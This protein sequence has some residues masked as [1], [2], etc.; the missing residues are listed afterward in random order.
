MPWMSAGPGAHRPPGAG[1]ILIMAALPMEVRP[2]L[3]QAKARP[4]RDLGVP[5]WEWESGSGVVALSGMGEAAARRAGET[6]IG[7]CRPWLLVSWGFAGALA[8][9]L[10]V[11]DLVL[12]ESFWH[13]NPD[14]RELKAGC[15]PQPPLPLPL[16]SR[17]LKQAGLQAVSRS[18]VSTTRI[19]HKARQGDSLAGLPQPVLDLE[20][21]ALAAVAAAHRLAF[22]SLRAI[23]DAAGEEIPEF[24]RAAGVQ[25]TA[26][27][28]RGAL[29]WLAADCRRVKDLYVLWGRSR[30]AAQALARAWLVLWPLLLAAG[31]EFQG[32]PAQEG[33][34]DENPHPAQAALADDEGHGQ[35]KA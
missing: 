8:P 28:V 14:A 31:G 5:A 35:V 19:I 30:R 24:L 7:R 23:T 33:E 34:I 2:F 26:V 22:L 29:R 20:T 15:Q 12:G 27:G 17:A 16:L 11:G 1:P 10:A 18:L 25:A 4:R 21:A 32:Q 3:R 9:G 13:Y 6:L